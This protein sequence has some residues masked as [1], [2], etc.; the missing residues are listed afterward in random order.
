M[1]TSA[2]WLLQCGN[3]LSIAV[4][5]HVM[6]EYVQ[7]QNAYTVPG[8]PGYC[9]SVIVWQGHIVPVM[10]LEV[11]QGTKA[12]SNQQEN[13]LL[14]ILYYQS[15]PNTPLKHIAL[16]VTG[17]PQK[18]LV[19]DEN[20]CEVPESL[21]SSPLGQVNLACFNHDELPVMVVDITRLC[22]AEFRELA[23]AA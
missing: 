1:S 12:S 4:G 20:A 23:N 7:Q 8:A 11:L 21:Q 5:D 9:S 18:V 16:R 22:S 14:C 3:S 6:A 2:A 13:P 15:E 19:A 17:T 10:D